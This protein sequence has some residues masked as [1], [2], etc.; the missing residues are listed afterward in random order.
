ML[1]IILLKAKSILRETKKIEI[2]IFCTI[3]FKS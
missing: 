1:I 3:I 2:C